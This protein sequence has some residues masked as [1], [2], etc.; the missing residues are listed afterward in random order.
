VSDHDGKVV[1]ITGCA[2][3]RGMGRA[4]AVAFARAGADIVATDVVA[5]GTRNENEECLEETRLNCRASRAWPPRSKGSGA[6]SQRS[7]VT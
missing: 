4:M 6:A 2:R 3:A 5:G 1:L 7:S